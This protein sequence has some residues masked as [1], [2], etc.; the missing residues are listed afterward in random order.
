[1]RELVLAID[2]TASATRLG[3]FRG[4]CA[5][6]AH[7]ARFL[8]EPQVSERPS[9]Q[10]APRVRATRAFLDGAG[11]EGRA[12]AAVAASG[13]LV[14]PVESGTYL[15]DDALLRDCERSERGH[16][17]ANVGALIARAIADD[18]GCP[19]FVVDPLSVDELDPVARFS[20][21]AGVQRQSI[22]HAL[23]MRAV[24]RRHALA[25]ERPLEELNLIVVRL[26]AAACLSAQRG[27]RLV[28]VVNPAAEGPFSGEQAGGL[29]TAAVA[30]MCFTPGAT[31]EG[32]RLRLAESG[33]LRSHLG[34]RDVR[35][36]EQQAERD[37]ARAMVV[38]DAMAYQIAKS[39]GA[40][41]AALGGE[42]DAVL[43]SGSAADATALV[44]G[45][46]RRVEWIAPVFVYPGDD[47][48]LALA[49]GALGVI[50]G[51]EQGRRYG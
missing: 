11:V 17:P 41:A 47:D 21:M 31:E 38:L 10:V 28:D 25:V 8:R 36:V 34:T 35:D 5:V 14:K 27:G 2:P 3:L 45:V 26:G 29:P 23:G 44:N 16:H 37:D 12:L 32:V 7:V 24:A 33:G 48:L 6:A 20:G 40:L 1:M 50:R 30:S 42:V 18:H 13:G 43:L 51:E 46:C 22:G 9:D 4:E 49:R 15:V 39:I 19:A